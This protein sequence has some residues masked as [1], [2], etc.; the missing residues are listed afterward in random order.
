[1]SK[2]R[3]NVVVLCLAAV[4]AG[5]CAT[6][7]PIPADRYFRVDS[8]LPADCCESLAA[9]FVITPL[10]A[11]G[12]Y[13][14]RAV[15]L[16]N[17]N[18][19]ELTQQRYDFWV[20]SPGRMLSYALM[21]ALRARGAEALVLERGRPEPEQIVVAGRI[22][23]FELI[24]EPGTGRYQPHIAIDFEIR[25]AAAG[26]LFAQRFEAVGAATEYQDALAGKGVSEATSAV[27]AALTGVLA[28]I[29]SARR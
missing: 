27:F 26:L 9:E 14:D 16:A 29:L 5:A 4:F 28:D 15:L 21:E 25:S 13:G 1:M 3:F 22:D 12:L 8:T 11:D 7:D 19:T 20:D 23:R 10:R 2:E 17:P 24:R 6:P 18:G